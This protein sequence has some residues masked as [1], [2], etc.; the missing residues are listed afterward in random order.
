MQVPPEDSAAF[1]KFLTDLAYPYK[2]E[3]SNP[4]YRRYLRE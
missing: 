1:D 3:T 4:V 2:E